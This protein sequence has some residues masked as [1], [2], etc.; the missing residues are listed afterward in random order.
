MIMF[1]YMI[2]SNNKTII[3]TVGFIITYTYVYIY[4]YVYPYKHGQL[5]IIS[6]SAVSASSLGIPA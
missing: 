2:T 1:L 3:I 4:A 5:V 6:E